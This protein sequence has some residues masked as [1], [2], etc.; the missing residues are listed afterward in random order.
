MNID[1]YIITKNQ[2]IHVAS[3]SGIHSHVSVLEPPSVKP[4]RIDLEE[5]VDEVS[6]R[7]GTNYAPITDAAQN[8][9]SDDVEIQNDGSNVAPNTSDPATWPLNRNIKIIITL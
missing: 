6:Q 1:K 8:D 5:I 2:G 7:N 9:C 4:D 3:T